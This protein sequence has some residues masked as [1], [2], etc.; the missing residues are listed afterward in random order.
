MPLEPDSQVT[1]L[2]PPGRAEDYGPGQCGLPAS[3][4]RQSP[5]GPAPQEAR[6]AHPPTWPRLR[7]VA[8]VQVRSVGDGPEL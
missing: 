4:M 2:S 5:E 7:L 3:S 1:P 6:L 8:L